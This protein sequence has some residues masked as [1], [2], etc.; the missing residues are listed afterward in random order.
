VRSGQRLACHP[1]ANQQTGGVRVRKREFWS[2]HGGQQG[3]WQLVSLDLGLNMSIPVR[4]LHR[5]ICRSHSLAGTCLA[6]G[7]AHHKSI[8]CPCSGCSCPGEPVRSAAHLGAAAPARCSPSRLRR[9]R[10]PLQT[11]WAG[12]RSSPGA[13]GPAARTPC[14]RGCSCSSSLLSWRTA[15]QRSRSS[16]GRRG[17]PAPRSQS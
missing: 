12:F 1:A 4:Q 13:P 11:T 10:W 15:R 7:K 8:P 6:P 14:A 17:R 2:T 3:F 9:W 16:S 5:R